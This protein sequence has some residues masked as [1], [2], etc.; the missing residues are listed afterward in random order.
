[1]R[2]AL[3]QVRAGVTDFRRASLAAERAAVLAPHSNGL[4][5]RLA[6]AG[7]RPTTGSRREGGFSVRAVAEDSPPDSGPPPGWLTIA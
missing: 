1:M 5:D 2:Q 4:A 6:S 7:A 3:V